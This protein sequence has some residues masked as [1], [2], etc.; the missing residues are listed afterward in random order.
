MIN[1]IKP[2]AN[3]RSTYIVQISLTDEDELP[4]TPLTLVWTLR[5]AAGAVVNGRE[6]VEVESPQSAVYITLSGD[7]LLIDGYFSGRR[8]LSLEGTYN[9]TLAN[10]VAIRAAAAFDVDRLSKIGAGSGS[11][12]ALI[13]RLSMWF[14][15]PS[16]DK[17]GPQVRVALINEAKKKVIAA[18]PRHFLHEL[19]VVFPGLTLDAEGAYDLGLLADSVE[20][21]NLSLDGVRLTD[22][23]FCRLISFEEWR[24]AKNR[25]RTYTER[26]PVYWRRGSRIYVEPTGTT[27]DLH[28]QRK[29]EDLYL[30]D[31]DA[32]KNVNCELAEELQD[33]MVEYAAYWGLMYTLQEEKLASAAFQT[34]QMDLAALTGTAT[35]TDSIT[36][37]ED[38]WN[39]TGE[40]EYFP[41]IMNQYIP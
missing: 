12:A 2:N 36:N 35:P 34:Y 33:L 6:N 18:A 27:I 10:G 25:S 21:G 16:M 26:N 39:E 4:V 28:Y 20:H 9:S 13:E 8:I 17:V 32:S 38:H 7:D 19:D 41:T 31:S 40:V 14:S 15:D 29:T 37:P 23:K 22:G 30:D 5:D 1:I 11:V 3:E 24:Q